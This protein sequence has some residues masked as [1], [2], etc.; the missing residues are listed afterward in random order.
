M[1][2]AWLTTVSNMFD[3]AMQERT[4]PATGRPFRLDSNPCEFVKRFQP[5]KKDDLDD[6]EDGHPTF[7]DED[8][9]AFEAAYPT[10]PLGG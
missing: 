4:D 9:A 5:L 10:A 6:E 1:A 8:L 2:N 3:W 7:T